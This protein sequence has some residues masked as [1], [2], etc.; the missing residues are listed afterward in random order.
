MLLADIADAQDWLVWSKTKDGRKNRN[1][2]KPRKRP[3]VD[4][5]QSVKRTKGE[6]LPIDQ[7]K[8]RLDALRRRVSTTAAEEKVRRVKVKKD[9]N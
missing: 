7:F 5:D 8:D 2:P 1:H 9:G 4:P 3:G 6:A